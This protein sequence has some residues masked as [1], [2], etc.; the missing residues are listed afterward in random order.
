[1]KKQNIPLTEEEV[2]S[3]M[4]EL[5]TIEIED[6][7]DR[8]KIIERSEKLEKQDEA[9]LATLMARGGKVKH[10]KG[11][12]F[13]YNMG[14]KVKTMSEYMKE[15]L[16]GR[17]MLEQNF[18]GGGS[19][20]DIML[21][22]VNPMTAAQRPMNYGGPAKKKYQEDGKVTEEYYKIGG[23]EVS[24]EIYDLYTD[25]GTKI[26]V[27]PDG[28]IPWQEA[29]GVKVEKEP[30]D[31]TSNL[32]K[33]IEE[34]NVEN[35]PVAP[36]DFTIDDLYRESVPEFEDIDEGVNKDI[37][38]IP[39]PPTKTDDFTVSDLYR[40]TTIPM[41]G[42]PTIPSVDSDQRVVKPRESEYKWPGT[43]NWKYKGEEK[44]NKAL[45]EWEANKRIPVKTM[46]E[47]QAE[48]ERDGTVPSYED[49]STAW[50]LENP[51]GP[52]PS[53]ESFTAMWSDP[54]P[55]QLPTDDPLNP[56]Y[57]PPIGD[58]DNNNDGIPDYLEGQDPLTKEIL[59]TSE[60]HQIH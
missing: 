23:K 3:L 36:V 58:I 19:I 26:Y 39:T 17:E 54:D 38:N 29:E 57:V 7:A 37:T 14:G 24:K 35:I 4:R 31:L 2:N 8:A 13:T 45:E 20:S 56:N 42:A 46:S 40:E 9:D 33:S 55:S 6:M 47:I 32:L 21:M 25:G 60:L 34:K 16:G 5:K 11:G 49:W 43:E 12:G 18:Q 1:M 51:D 59:D 50:Q 28:L 27:G 41:E 15:M 48:F 22:N 53:E 10:K 30:S 52:V 44:Y